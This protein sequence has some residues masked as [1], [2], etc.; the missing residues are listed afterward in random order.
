M[1]ELHLPGHRL[2]AR[3]LLGF[4]GATSASS[5]TRIRASRLI[6]SRLT[7]SSISENSSNASFLYSCFGCFCA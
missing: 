4:G 3:A 2:G 7:F 6:T 1:L 5:R